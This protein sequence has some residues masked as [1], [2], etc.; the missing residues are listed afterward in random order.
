MTHTTQQKLGL[1]VGI[2]FVIAC[3]ASIA[4]AD[5]VPAIPANGVYLG[6]S[7]S[8]AIPKDI[9]VTNINQNVSKVFGPNVEYT[10]QLF[11]AADSQYTI[12]DADK[13]TIHV[14]PGVASAV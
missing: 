7:V 5:P 10:F 6:N 8:I 9:T 3:I 2:L 14:L 12:T 1:L 13:N 4:N 11:P